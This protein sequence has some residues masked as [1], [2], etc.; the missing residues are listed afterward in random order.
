MSHEALNSEQFGDYSLEYAKPDMYI[1]RHRIVAS[2]S[3]ERAGEMTWH[4]KTH[5]ITGINVEEGDRR[6]GLAT[7]MWKMGQ[8]QRPKPVHS[9]DRTRAGEAWAKSVG[10]RLPRRKPVFDPVS[11]REV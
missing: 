5:A 6:Q 1:P 3:G 10:G 9:A 8:Q 4:P 11:R 2:K 7:A